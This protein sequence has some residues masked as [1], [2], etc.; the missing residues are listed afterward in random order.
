VTGVLGGRPL[1][2]TGDDGLKAQRL[3]DAATAAARTG[4]AMR[5]TPGSGAA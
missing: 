1:S 4:K 5:L 2:P 3:A